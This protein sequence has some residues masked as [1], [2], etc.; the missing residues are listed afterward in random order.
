MKA[1]Q[2]ASKSNYRAENCIQY[3]VTSP[4]QQNCG[5]QP[6]SNSTNKLF[7]FRSK[8]ILSIRKFWKFDFK[9]HR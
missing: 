9:K 2:K 5:I 6:Y 3:H 7:L 1:A 8:T 4:V